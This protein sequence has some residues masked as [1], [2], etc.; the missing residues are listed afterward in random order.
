[1]RFSPSQTRARQ[2]RTE[3]ASITLPAAAAIAPRWCR[4]FSCD[5][6]SRVSLTATVTVRPTTPL[7]GR[8]WQW[9]KIAWVLTA[10]AIVLL[11]LIGLPVRYE[12]VRS[13]DAALRNPEIRNLIDAGVRPAVAATLDSIAEVVPFAVMFTGG[14]ALF[15]RGTGSREALFLSFVMVC[16][17]AG[18]G[19]I[20]VHRTPGP[21]WSQSAAGMAATVILLLASLL[22][23][24]AMFWFPQGRFVWWWTAWWTALQTL[25]FAG[26]YLLA[27]Y[28]RAHDL[29]NAVGA[30]AVIVGMYAQVSHYRMVRD[31][32]SR[33]QIKW[34]MVGAVLAA[35]GFL[36]Y[37]FGTMLIGD[38]AD[39][40]A[41]LLAVLA[42][43]AVP[44]SEIGFV[45]CLA[46]A[47]RRYRLWRID[48]VINRSLVYGA[49]T[50]AVIVILLGGGFTL[51]RL[52]GDD[53]TTL[54]FAISVVAAAVAFSP[55]RQ[56]AQRFVDRRLF[57]LRFD[58]DE[59]DR[60]RQLPRIKMPGAL[61]GRT[62]GRYHLLAVLG[63]G[64]M[65]EV[66]QAEADGRRVAVKIVPDDLA[67]EAEF[68]HWF[69]REAQALATLDHPNI[70]KFHEAGESAGVH[71]IVLD[72]IEGCELSRII[73]TEQRL[74]LSDARDLVADCAA[75]L[76]YA[77][78]R[79]LVHRDIKPS[80]IMVRRIGDERPQAVLMDFGVA[81]MRESQTALTSTGAV[82]TIQYMA[83]EQIRAAPTVDAR[84]DIYAL[85]VTAYEMVTG[86][87]PF[88]GNAGQLV[89]AHLQEHPVDPRELVPGLPA[90]V[91]HA[92]MRALRKHPAERFQTALDFAAGFNC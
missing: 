48:L 87:L 46:I 12:R 78:R 84:A 89:F 27:P 13:A 33:Q 54:A 40:G 24:N 53:Y 65:G 52:L 6:A 82:G 88:R 85:G 39:L 90:P 21:A 20:G 29:V 35:T 66:Y 23:L 51:Q 15:L 69:R 42:R 50:V 38:R 86:V 18:A 62:L 1:M 59:L 74:E 45:M 5:D 10:A 58:L 77:H 17:S 60:G 26:L 37:E 67:G 41:R 7:H 72:Y 2:Y 80:N 22:P 34:V 57:G 70:V 64:A 61:T 55:A 91:A 3:N 92:I 32:G 16:W 19:V 76:D 79:G 8:S 49:V 56:R 71:Y 73:K 44:A 30:P 75:A 68:L 43:L 83:P 9:L 81:K 14:A 11:V 36:V 28:P 31:P 47:I 25:V 63:R 4:A